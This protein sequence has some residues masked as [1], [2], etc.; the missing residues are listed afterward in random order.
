MPSLAN[1]YHI[2]SLHVPE[3]WDL[4][5]TSHLQ[6]LSALATRRL[7]LSHPLIQG[8][9]YY[10]YMLGGRVARPLFGVDTQE[11]MALIKCLDEIDNFHTFLNEDTVCPRT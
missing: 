3:R 6:P 1:F 4:S 9:V 8:A 7:E 2:F 11:T 10:N 5:H